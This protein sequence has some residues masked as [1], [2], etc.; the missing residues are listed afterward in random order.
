MKTEVL[1]LGCLLV[2]RSLLAAD[3]AAPDYEHDI[4]PIFRNRCYSCHG[5][6][7]QESDLR[8]DSGVFIREGGTGGSAVIPG[9]PASSPLVLRITSDDD[10]QRMPPEGEPLT[11]EQ[12]QLIRRWIAA[13]AESPVSERSEADPGQHWAFQVPVRSPLPDVDHPDWVRNPIDAFI[14]AAHEKHGLTP[15][16]PAG[17]E[18]LLRRVY[19]DLIGLPPTRQQLAEFRADDSQDGYEKVVDRLLNSPQYGERWGRH[20]MDVWRYSDWYGRRSANDVRNSSAQ[21][22]RWRDWIVQ[23]LNSDKGYDRMIL[24]MLAGD[25]LA[26]DDPDVVVATGFIVRNCYRP[27]FHTWK[28]DMV[29]HTG[30]AFLGLRFNCAHCHDHKYDPIS[31]KE[32]FQFRA[33]FEPLM[34]RH[35]RLPGLPAPVRYTV[36]DFHSNGH[37]PTKAGLARVYD[38][39][40]DAA[41]YMYRGGDPRDVMPDLPPVAPGVPAALGGEPLRVAEIALPSVAFFPGAQQFVQQEET[42]RARETVA[43]AELALNQTRGELEMQR[44]KFEEKI[45]AA[46]IKVRAAQ[47][48]LAASRNGPAAAEPEARW[49]ANQ[50]PAKRLMAYWQFEA[51]DEATKI[52]SDSS[53]NN[54]TLLRS[55]GGDARV[56][57]FTLPLTGRGRGFVR[58]TSPHGGINRECLLFDERGG[59]SYLYAIAGPALHANEL[60]IEMYLHNTVSPAGRWRTLVAYEGCWALEQQSLS[61]STNELRLQLTN[62]DGGLREVSTN[63]GEQPLL[64]VSGH[65]YYLAA[66]VGGEQITLWA[67][68]LTVAS[69]LQSFQVPRDNEQDFSRLARPRP[70]AS[71]TI[72]NASGSERHQGL[73]DEIRLTAGALT[74]VEMERHSEISPAQEQLVAAERALFAAR[75][76]LRIVYLTHTLHATQLEGARLQQAALEARLA[77]DMARLIHKSPQAAA[78]AREA[79]RAERMAALASAKSQL[80]GSMKRLAEVEL[81]LWSDPQQAVSLAQAE[82][83]LQDARQAVAHAV[84]KTLEPPSA[85]YTSITEAFPQRSTGRRTALARWIVGTNNPLTARV[86]VNHMWLR[87]FGSPFVETVYDFGR[88]GKQPSLPELLDWLA[89]EL[90]QNGWRMKHI[91]QMIVTSSTYRMQSNVSQRDQQNLSADPKNRFLWHFNSRRMEAENVRDGILAA[92]GQLDLSLGGQ[93]IDIQYGTTSPRRSLYFTQHP[94]GGRLQF[95]S[96]FDPPDPCDAYRRHDSVVPQQALA[97]TNSRL[98]L[99]Q[100]RLLARRLWQDIQ[101]RYSDETLREAAFVAAAFAQILSRYPTSDEAAICHE[102]LRKQVR[103]FRRPDAKNAAGSTPEGSIAPASD[104]W[105]RARESLVGAVYCH[106]DFVTVR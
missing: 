10:G 106:N 73:L 44:A 82:Q 43:A 20:W 45:P 84:Q 2:T 100:S 74:Q 41:T 33:F 36:Y 7:K 102:F 19:L 5:G 95:M 25:E 68:D 52:L 23:S 13:G 98:M 14:S 88:S 15:S 87:H 12:I 49:A 1:L 55:T 22:W 59:D 57:P 56:P 34:L 28:Q 47:E 4:K 30:K 77:A 105:M 17:K 64:L 58:P 78:A 70:R 18:V 3:N 90:M 6:L 40:L 54:H 99:N 26:P 104:P 29:E 72:G 69:E 67:K 61:S 39:Q 31:Q 50:P 42:A 80:A 81:A 46:E 51:L 101:R 35:D 27:N 66:V 79:G 92:A 103:L 96:V 71:F 48:A 21:I 63:S 32:Y 94:E 83:Q 53:G 75:H 24:E 97:L 16:A 65:D 37:K 60:T 91:H 86:A 85:E 38:G 62:T 76:Q 9:K 8:L 89:I 11:K 93:D